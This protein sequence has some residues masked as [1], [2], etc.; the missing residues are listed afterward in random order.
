VR[1]A[2]ESLHLVHFDATTEAYDEWVGPSRL[3]AAE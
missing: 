2:S 1:A 3:R